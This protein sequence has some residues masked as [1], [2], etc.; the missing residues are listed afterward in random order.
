MSKQRLQVSR[1]RIIS[2]F[3]WKKNDV[4]IKSFDKRLKEKKER[5]AGK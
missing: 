4:T 1:D 3:C 5:V 2:K